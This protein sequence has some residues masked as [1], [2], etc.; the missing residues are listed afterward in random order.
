MKHFH[1]LAVPCAFAALCTGIVHADDDNRARA[2]LSG[3]QEV[4]A[5]A[6]AATGTFEARLLPNSSFTFELSYRGLEGNATQA[7]IHF[8]QKSVNGGVSVFLCSNLGN[9]PAG[10]QSC[11]SPGGT[12][13]GTI[14][15]ASVIGP[16]GQDISPG[17]FDELIRA[18][19]AGVTYANVHS[20]KFPAG[21]ARGQ[22]KVDD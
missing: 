15:A 16:L 11:P 2:R 19:R 21:E 13:T 17:Q 4:P 18:M 22:I 9:A 14:T 7:H 10:T 5:L 6:S 12:V 8:G 1:L 20:T 3:F